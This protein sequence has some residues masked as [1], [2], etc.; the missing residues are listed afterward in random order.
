MALFKNAMK[1]IAEGVAD[2]SSLEVTTFSG[3]VV[4]KSTTKVDSF[5]QV[6]TAAKG[7]QT[8]NMKVLAST[9][10]NLDGD[11]T[12]F[13]DADIDASEKAAH[14]QLVAEASENRRET[15]EMVR[16]IVGDA[17]SLI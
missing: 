5:E 12:T 13:F 1:K 14:N 7:N 15:I 6:F 9:K 4:I 3:S 17:A 11:V 8:V 10:V 16:E 2:M